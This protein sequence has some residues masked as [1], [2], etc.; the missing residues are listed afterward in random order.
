VAAAYL[1]VRNTGG[2][3]DTLAEVTGD[4]FGHA[5]VMGT[6]D[7][8]MEASS[9]LV[10]PPGQVV[11]MAPGGIHVMVEGVTSNPAIGDTLRLVLRFSLAGEIH[12]AIPVVAYGEMP[13]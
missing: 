10:I 1:R 7:G 6:T 2:S 8:H 3:A 9:P 12:I 13:E 5:T 11:T 4:G